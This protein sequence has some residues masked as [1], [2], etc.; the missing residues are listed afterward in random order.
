MNYMDITEQI[1][2]KTTG[3]IVFVSGNFNILHPGHLRLLRFAKECGDYLVV[4][5][6]DSN[7]EGSHLQEELRL[8]G[9][10]A[11]HWVD[12]AFIL[13]D[14][15]E[16]FIEELRPASVVKGKEHEYR[17]NPELEVLASYGGK[18]QFCSGDMAFSSVDLMRQ[19]MRELNVSTIKVPHDYLSRHGIEPDQSLEILQ[20]MRKLRVCVIGDTIVDE[21][22]ACDALGMSQEDPTIVVT[23]VMQERF[24]GGAAIVAAHARSLGSEVHFFSVAGR[25][26]TSTFVTSSLSGFGVHYHY[27]E[28]DT[29]PTTLKQRF[30]VGQKTLLRVSHLRQHDVRAEIRDRLLADI[31][32]VLDQTDLL[33]FADFNYGCLPQAL[34][35]DIVDE[36][37]KR[38]VVMAADSQSSSQIGDVSRFQNMVLVT[39]TEREA[40]LA[41]QD[42]DSGLVV[43][44]A[45]LQE[46]AT[47]ENVV[48]TLGA[49]GLL[50]QA[51]LSDT[52]KWP[53]DRLPALNL[54]PK[55]VAG[56]GDSF[57]TC[58]AMALGVGADIWQ[59]SYL[60]ALAAACQVGRVGNIP[61]THDELVTEII[62]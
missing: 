59:A 17:F 14:L 10:Q 28:D 15:P 41:L 26:E 12:Y 43:L 57:L 29:R 54:A 40:R 51:G 53:T 38:G 32:C 50:I 35:A 16:K 25:D 61:L 20:R 42:F 19:E 45:K 49:E 4:G 8:E 7:S 1:R 11:I 31:T 52:D 34:V 48:I 24:V 30:R 27:Y 33:I 39:P 6:L 5:V 9:V 3:R 58:A 2:A 56:A 60:G 55:D 44:A 47:A 21:Y 18:L 36:C 23:P 46:K 37:R 22:I 13:R 62:R